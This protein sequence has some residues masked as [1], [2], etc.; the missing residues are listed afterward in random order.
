MRKT[1]LYIVKITLFLLIALY[2]SMSF[3]QTSKLWGKVIDKHTGNPISY[4]NISLKLDQDSLRIVGAI[5]NAEGVFTIRDVAYGN[6]RLK[7]SFIGYDAAV[8]NPFVINQSQYDMGTTALSVSSKNLEEVTVNSEKRGISYQVDRKIINAKSFPGADKAIDLLENMPSLQLDVDGRLTYRGDGTFLVYINGR[9]ELNGEEK[10]RQI[11]ADQIQYIEIITNPT[12]KYDAEG[13]AG[14]IQVILK[15]SRLE[16]YAI[17]TSARFSTLG[18]YEWIFS[19]DQKGKKGGWYIQGQLDDFVQR[20]FTTTSDQII[21]N[22]EQEYRTFSDLVKK[23]RV[24]NSY[25]EFGLNY[26]LSDKDY[27][28]FMLSADPVRRSSKYTDLGF[29]KESEY[30][31]GELLGAESYDYESRFKMYYRYL[32]AVTTYEHAFTKDRSH[33]LTVYAD[34]S[35]YLHPLKESKIDTKT[36]I[37]GFEKLG[38]LAKEYNEMIVETNVAYKNKFSDKSTLEIGAE[39]NL[40]H[41]PKVTTQS[42]TFDERNRLRLFEDEKQAQKVR[43]EQNIFSGYATFES[44]FG[45]L[46]YKLGIRMEHTRRKSNYSYQAEDDSEIE[47]PAEKEFT[48]FFP[49]AHL[50]YNFS[51][52]NQLS[53]N[54]SRRIGRADYYELIPL[55][56]YETPYI[57]YTGNGNLMPSYSNAYELGYI[58]SWGDNFV[59]AEIFARTTDDLIQSYYRRGENNTVI[60]TKENV[61]KS[62]SAGTELMAGYDIFK[63]WNS[64]LSTSL[65][66]YRLTVDLDNHQNEQE[67]MRGDVRFNNTFKIG[68]TF[69]VRYLFAYLSPFLNAQVKRDAYTYSD[70]ALRKSFMKRKWEVEF[71]WANVF[72]SIRY[73]TITRGDGLYVESDFVRKPYF[74]F[75][76]SYRFNNQ[77]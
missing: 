35:T 37:D 4:A 10:L 9:P 55:K 32:R 33:L 62:L 53:M 52:D 47:I 14:I 48:D 64:N 13:T 58:R 12:A 8:V 38:Y 77:N 1:V 46:D 16:G 40:D 49:S 42:G 20:K 29:Y 50:V 36:F 15:R 31:S 76:L 43:F 28:D 68:K 34:Y 30:L 21:T 19:I 65:Y 57:Y 73:S 74:T 66:L 51:D 67:Q 45:K 59:S 2:G 54:Y 18:S 70:L 27:I 44:S 23:E 3:A 6:Y 41:I 22:G 60:W 25:L 7:I 5:T 39:I 71:S 17:N 56:R 72:N 26:D 11:P 75:K 24:N 63:W 61:G 69:S